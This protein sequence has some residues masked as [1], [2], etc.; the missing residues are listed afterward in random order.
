M[1]IKAGK[2]LQ[3]LSAALLLQAGLFYA[4]SRAENVPTMRPLRDFPIAL[5]PW[6][7]TKEGYIDEETQKVLQ[8][9]DTLTRIYARAG[10]MAQ[11][12]LFVAYFRTQRT[13]KAP[14]SPKNCLPGSGWEPSREDYLTVEAPG[15]P[16]PI[17]VN[18]YIV[19][20]GENQSI[21]LYWYQSQHR[22][23]A[24]EYEA[25]FWTVTD[26]IRYN[27]TDTALVRVVVPIVAGN[28]DAAQDLA[29]EFVRTF[30]QPLK[31]HLP[32]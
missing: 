11:S 2:Y 28:E 17:E 5:G 19:A 14:H 9:D 18:R 4:T 7:M 1:A 20:K 26:A 31:N 3:I 6:V 8:A 27:R 32:A 24:S 16:Q 12:S 23:I 10:T 13:G 22:V 21:V 30:F 15:M 29:V 25:K